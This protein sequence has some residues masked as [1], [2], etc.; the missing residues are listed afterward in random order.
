MKNLL[1]IF[2]RTDIPGIE[3]QEFRQL[4]DQHG[5]KAVI[6][7]VRSRK[8]F[9]SGHIPG[10]RNI[11][12]H[13][14]DFLDKAGRYGKDACFLVYCRSGQR[15]MVACKVLHTN[16]YKAVYNLKGGILR[17]PYETE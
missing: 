14:R 17:W 5:K 3:P 1:A 6:L 10:A 13:Q 12:V 4:Q 8:E 9:L 7:D 11:S 2:R 15:S 16:G